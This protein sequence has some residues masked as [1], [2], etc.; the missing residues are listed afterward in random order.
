MEEKV[1]VRKALRVFQIIIT[2]GKRT[3]DEYHLNGLTAY[4]DFDGCT[5]TI[6]NDYVRLDIFFH[7]KIS[8]TYSN[9]KEKMLFLEKINAMD[10]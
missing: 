2:D 6:R 3:G 10:K 1:N 7:N 9:R 8:F 5:A 4:T